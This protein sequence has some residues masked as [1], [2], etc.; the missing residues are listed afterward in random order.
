MASHLASLWKWDF[1]EL[2][3]GLLRAETVTNLK[4]SGLVQTSNFSRD[5]PSEL[6]SWEV[7]RLAQLSLSEWVWIVQ[8]VLSVC[9]R[10]VERLNI[11]SGTNVNLHMRRTKLIHQRPSVPTDDSNLI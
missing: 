11:V 10:R 6:S 2:G 4:D 5:E 7:R 8:H 9:F 3:N 1:L